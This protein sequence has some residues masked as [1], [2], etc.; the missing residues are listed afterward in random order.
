[1]VLRCS[2]VDFQRTGKVVRRNHKT[3]KYTDREGERENHHSP[4]RHRHRGRPCPLAASAG[5]RLRDQDA[6]SPSDGPAGGSD[7]GSGPAP[8]LTRPCPRTLRGEPRCTEGKARDDRRARPRALIIG[9]RGG[10]PPRRGGERGA[11]ADPHR[12]P[13]PRDRRR[14]ED[15]HRSRDRLEY[16]SWPFFLLY[17]PK[18]LERV[19]NSIRN[20]LGMRETEIA[21]EP[22][23]P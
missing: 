22:S 12:G 11:M 6:G 23:R 2:S 10:V 1:M 3:V 9:R 8:D 13:S 16:Y 19:M 15:Q 21:R 20:G 17:S 5:R 14:A 7:G 18:S 4:S